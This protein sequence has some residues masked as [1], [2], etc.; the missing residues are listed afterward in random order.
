LQNARGVN[1]DIL[2]TIIPRSTCPISYSLDIFGDKWTL[3][4]L[5]DMIFAN[6]SSYSEFMCSD[7]RIASNILI[8]RLGMLIS[9][10]FITKNIA[11]EKKSKIVYWL[12]DKGIEIVP[13][14]I[15]LIEWGSKYNPAGGPKPILEKIARNKTATI[16]G[17][18]QEIKIK[19]DAALIA[20]TGLLGPLK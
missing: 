18:Q 20:I 7:E 10:G 17:I 6:K 13:L 15:E 8:D 14:I 3:L 5:R 12:T 2:K 16:K 19:R 4:I 1:H 11:P 9:E